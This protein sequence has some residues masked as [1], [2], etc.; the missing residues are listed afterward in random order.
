[1]K[2]IIF[3]LLVLF[4]INSFAQ[5]SCD[6]ILKTDSVAMQKPSVKEEVQVAEVK[7]KN[8]YLVQFIKQGPK[9][10]L[11]LTVRD[12]LGYGK[13]CALLLYCNKKQIYV[14][15]TTL[16][17]ADKGSAYFLVELVPNYISTLKENGL[18]NIIFCEN[19]EFVVPKQD[20][21]AVK[22]LAGCFYDVAVPQ[23]KKL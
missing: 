6:N 3:L 14:K 8:N 20:A 5:I 13:T 17:V 16:M 23:P 21:E 12:N 10:Y 4:S 18:T 9:N 15:S 19:A 7:I 2:K 1:M 22:K 11:K